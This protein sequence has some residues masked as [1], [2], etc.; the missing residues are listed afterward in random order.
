VPLDRF[1]LP[2]AD[3]AK[4]ALGAE[5]TV[6]WEHHKNHSNILKNIRMTGFYIIALE[7]SKNS[8]DYKKVK[9]KQKTAIIVGNEVRGLPQSIL[10][11]ADTI[12]EIP[13]KGKKESLNVSVATGIFLFRILDI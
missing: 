11:Y 7:Q 13:L 5:K 9:V 2:R 6:P 3:L 12:A 1:G 4:S 10:K 8:V